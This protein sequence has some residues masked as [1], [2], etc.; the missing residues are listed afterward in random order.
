MRTT[1]ARLAPAGLTLALGLSASA[2]PVLP[3]LPAAVASAAEP[4]AYRVTGV[5]TSHHNHR[6]RD[7]RETAT[8]D[9]R[10]VAASES[11]AFL[12]ATQHTTHTDRWFAADWR[13]ASATSLAR[14]PYHFFDPRGPRDGLAQAGHFVRTVRAAGYTG[15]RPGE[16]PPVLDVEKVPRG[17]KGRE[18]CPA[19]LRADQLGAFLRR[20]REEFRV[21]PIVYTRASFVKECMGGDGRVFAGYPLWLARYGSGAKEPAPVPGAAARWTFWQHTRS[22]HV[23]GVPTAVDRDVFAGGRD[24][25][26]ALAHLPADNPAPAVA[27]PV[28]RSG[29]TGPDVRSAQL[30]LGAD[31]HRVTADGRFGAD[32]ARAVRDF[33]RAH[34]LPAD[35]VVGA[36]TWTAL[37][38]TVRGGDSGPAVR[39]V[40]HQLAACGRQVTADGRFGPATARAVRDFQRA[41]RLS[42]D[43]VAGPTTWRA[44]LATSRG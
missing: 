27:W 8:I 24:G 30:L 22:G 42:P 35:G 31:G 14:A 36:R 2:L 4:A 41:H 13:A 1:L 33:Q 21:T 5:D 29:A 11:F 7:G 28:I 37:V 34:R 32:T 44:L 15:H 20:V 12:K 16:L 9:W 6:T 26:R 38:R 25:L 40:Q 3:V 17:P 10:K 18:V 19:E 23:A 39:A 43:G